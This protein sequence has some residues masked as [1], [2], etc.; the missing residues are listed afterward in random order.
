MF[1][2]HFARVSFRTGYSTQHNL[3][4]CFP[5]GADRPLRPDGV[6]RHVAPPPQCQHQPQLKTRHSEE[7]QA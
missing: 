2:G 4:Q 7:E 5:G 1:G 6:F 3:A